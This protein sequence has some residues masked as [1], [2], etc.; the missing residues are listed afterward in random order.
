MTLLWTFSGH[1]PHV[2]F[3][4]FPNG[5]SSLCAG[6]SGCFH[7]RM[8]KSRKKIDKTFTNFPERKWWERKLLKRSQ[9]SKNGKGWKENWQNLHKS[10]VFVLVQFVERDDC[11]KWTFFTLNSN[12]KPQKQNTF[13]C[14]SCTV[15]TM[16]K[17]LNKRQN[18]LAIIGV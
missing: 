7:T 11:S 8:E 5:H 12:L 2:S 13:S 1:S 18:I 16:Q 4:C 10:L 17:D 6:F 14:R 9:I 3:T 15:M